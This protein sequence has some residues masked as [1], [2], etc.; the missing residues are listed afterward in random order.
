MRYQAS[1][2]KLQMTNL[3]KSRMPTLLLQAEPL[4]SN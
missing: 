2:D 3:S 1:F 4:H